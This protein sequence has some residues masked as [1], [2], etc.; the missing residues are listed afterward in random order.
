MAVTDGVT[1]HG[2]KTTDQ[3]EVMGI[4]DKRQLAEAERA[5]QSRLVGE[6]ME[7][8][9]SFA[10]PARVDI[11]GSLKCGRDVFIDVNAIF[12]GDVELGDGARIESNNLIRDPVIGAG[13]AIH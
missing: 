9:V 1:V 7:Q 4:N 11:R 13:T 10:D 6:L 12:E 3:A 5:L 8:G 2:V